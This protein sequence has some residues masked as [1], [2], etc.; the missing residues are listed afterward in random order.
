MEGEHMPIVDLFWCGSTQG[1]I[2]D[3]V[4]IVVLVLEAAKTR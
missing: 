4:G 2:S 1:V 3:V